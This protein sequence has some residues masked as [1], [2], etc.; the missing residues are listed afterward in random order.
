MAEEIRMDCR[1]LSPSAK[2]ALL[3]VINTSLLLAEGNLTK[4]KRD[5]EA[6]DIAG[7]KIPPHKQ[8]ALQHLREDISISENL[9]KEVEK[10][11]EC[12]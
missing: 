5:L 10:I 4:L 6:Y 7:R 1:C 9:K 2:W 3:G 12:R 11:P 8:A